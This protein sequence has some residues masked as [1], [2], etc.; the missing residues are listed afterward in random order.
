MKNSVIPPGIDLGTVR[1]V[2]QRLNHYATPRP[3]I[4]AYGKQKLQYILL[5]I[6]VLLRGH[7]Q[8]NCNAQK[9]T[10]RVPRSMSER[11]FHPNYCNYFIFEFPCIISL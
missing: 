9:F 4:T 2:A 5:L 3:H 6:P 8:Q 11:F 10:E 1:L 7:L